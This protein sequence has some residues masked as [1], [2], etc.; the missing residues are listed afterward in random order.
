VVVASSVNNPTNAQLN[1]KWSSTGGGFGGSGANNTWQAPTQ[2]GVYDITLTVDDGKGA[3]AQAK[4]SITVSSNRAPAITSLTADPVNVNLGGSTTLTCVANDPD[5]D[6]VQYSWNASEGNINGSGG[7]VS[8]SSPSKAGTFAITCVVSD[9][10]GAESK[11]MI[12]VPV[13]PMNADITINMVKQESGTVSA[14]GNKDITVYRVGDDAGGV[15]YRAFFSY[16]IFSLNNTNVRVAKLK[17]LPARISGD[18]FGNLDGL[19]F[20]RVK[21][22]EGLPDYN[23]TGDNIFSAGALLKS[24]PN[25]V[26]ITPEIKSLISAGAKRFQLEALFWKATNGNNA[27]DNIEWPDVTMMVSFNP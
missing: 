20:W 24:S 26:D 2:A 13:G 22:G 18:P 1:Y 27:I 8:W 6:I 4:T 25:E 10:K 3:T 16:D 19:R 17:F 14:T 15:T 21:Y 7:K 11:Q 12:S 23:I 9:G 5:G